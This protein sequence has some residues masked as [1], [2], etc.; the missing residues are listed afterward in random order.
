MS[1]HFTTKQIKAEVEKRLQR[2]PGDAPWSCI[3]CYHGRPCL[4]KEMLQLVK[5]AAEAEVELFEAFNRC[6]YSL[7]D[8]ETGT[9]ACSLDGVNGSHCRCRDAAALFRTG[10]LIDF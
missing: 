4:E 5:V 2:H 10:P 1:S 3:E 6:R 7:P 8:H 9:S